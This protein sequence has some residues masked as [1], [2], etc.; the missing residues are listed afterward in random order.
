MFNICTLKR[1]EKVKVQSKVKN[2]YH[3]EVVQIQI[4]FFPR[5]VP[6]Q[7]FI[8]KVVV[9]QLVGFADEVVKILEESRGLKVC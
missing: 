1:K 6:E 2:L 4:E 8:E 7:Y 5:D 3:G 9:P